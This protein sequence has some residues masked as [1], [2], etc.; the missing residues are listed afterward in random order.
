MEQIGQAIFGTKFYFRV[1]FG[2]GVYTRKFWKMC[3][4]SDEG[5]EGGRVQQSYGRQDLLTFGMK[6]LRWWL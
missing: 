4:E 2:E 6:E 3:L 1:I 5:G